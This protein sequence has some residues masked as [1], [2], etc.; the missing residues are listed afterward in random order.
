METYWTVNEVAAIFQLSAKTIYRYVAN[1]EIPYHKINSSVRFCPS[2]IKKW[3]E[4]KKN[5]GA[6]YSDEI[7]PED[8]LFNNETDLE[9]GTV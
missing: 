7:L 2:E 5:A 4:D 1:N 6:E 8:T 3:I 9:G